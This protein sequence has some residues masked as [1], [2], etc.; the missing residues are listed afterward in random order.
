M[1]DDLS[2]KYSQFSGDIA[3]ALGVGG[4]SVMDA[5]KAACLSAGAN[6]TARELLSAKVDEINPTYL[7]AVPI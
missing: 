4:G 7:I 1:E 2:I 3:K 6:I 5:A